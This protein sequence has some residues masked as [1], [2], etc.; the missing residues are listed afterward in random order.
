[1]VDIPTTPKQ[2]FLQQDR[3]DPREEGDQRAAQ[4]DIPSELFDNDDR[5]DSLIDTKTEKERNSH[6]DQFLL[7][8][9]TPRLADD[10]LNLLASGQMKKGGK[11]S[12]EHGQQ[13]SFLSDV[14]SS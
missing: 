1:M 3:H 12:R 2:P 13:G 4:E 9:M 11:D 10:P 7:N 14:E 6:S 8:E 5:L